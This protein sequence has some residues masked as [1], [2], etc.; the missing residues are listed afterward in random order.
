MGGAI[1]RTDVRL[2]LDDSPLAPT[3]G[4]L[5]HEP[6]AEQLPRNGQRGPLV[7]LARKR[8]VR[9]ADE[10]AC[11]PRRSDREIKQ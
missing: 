5:V 10:Y 11:A 8:S 9:H 7:E 6:T 1:V 2:G 4:K 3:G